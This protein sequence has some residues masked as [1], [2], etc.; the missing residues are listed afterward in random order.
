[1]D[2]GRVPRHYQDYIFRRAK[3]QN[4]I[5]CL[6]TGSGKT[7]IAC[8]LMT[9]FASELQEPFSGSGKRIFFL[10]PQKVLVHQQAD[11]IRRTTPFSE[12]VAEI[13]GDND[14][15][16]WTAEKWNHHLNSF[17][18]FVMIHDIFRSLLAMGNVL[19]VEKISLIVLD[20]AHHAALKKKSK[21][22]NHP[23]RQILE[24]LSQKQQ[25]SAPVRLLGLT[26]SLINNR[27]TE[28]LVDDYISDLETA[29]LNAECIAVDTAEVVR[30][31]TNAKVIIWLSDASTGQR[32]DGLNVISSS[33]S[34]IKNSLMLSHKS[35]EAKKISFPIDC[36]EAGRV[37]DR[38]SQCI[39]EMSI[40]IGWQ[41]CREYHK[42]L[43]DS[44]DVYADSFSTYA[45]ILRVLM[46][47]VSTIADTL[48][49]LMKDLTEEEKIV[50]ISSPKLI[51]LL[52][53]LENYSIGQK[54]FRGI[55]FVETRLEAKAFSHWIQKVSQLLPTLSFVKAEYLTGYSSRPGFVDKISRLSRAHQQ[56]TMAK[57]RDGGLNLLVATSV[58]EEGLDVPECNCV[59]RYHLPKTY[60]SYQ[61]SMGR[62]RAEEA[63]FFLIC[64]TGKEESN[65]TRDLSD[66]ESLGETITAICKKDKNRR[67][68]LCGFVSSLP[69]DE[70]EKMEKLLDA[71]KVVHEVTGAEITAGTAVSRV[72]EYLAQLSFGWTPRPEN[73]FVPTGSGYI[74]EVQLPI[75][76]GIPN[77]IRGDAMSSE[78]HAKKSAY[79]TI[80]K[81]LMDLQL[82]D[83]HLRPIPKHVFVKKVL[84]HLNLDVP[85]E[86]IPDDGA[87]PGTKKRKQD[88][89]I[90][91]PHEELSSSDHYFLYHI[92]IDDP[93]SR[94]GSHRLA[95]L[96]AAELPPHVLMSITL[97]KKNRPVHV[98]IRSAG[99]TSL[100]RPS[101]QS[102]Q[103][104]HHFVFSQMLDFVSRV[105]AASDRRQ[106]LLVAPL[107]SQTG[108]IDV[109]YMDTLKWKAENRTS[110]VF[111][112]EGFG[113]GRSEKFFFD[114]DQYHDAVVRKWYGLPEK[115]T[116]TRDLKSWSQSWK[117]AQIEK[118]LD[119][120][121]PDKKI[122][123]AAYYA[124]K[125]KLVA[126]DRSQ[127]LLK[128]TPGSQ[129]ARLT[130]N[131]RIRAIKSMHY[132]P[133][134]CEVCPMSASMWDQVSCLPAF[135]HRLNQLRMALQFQLF[136]AKTV[137]LDIDTDERFDELRFVAAPIARNDSETPAASSSN[138]SGDQHASKYLKRT[139]H[140]EKP[141]DL[142]GDDRSEQMFLGEA[143]DR[144]VMHSKEAS[145]LKRVCGIVRRGLTANGRQRVYF[146]PNEMFL[147]Q[148]FHSSIHPTPIQILF[149][150]LIEM[151]ETCN[152]TMKKLDDVLTAATGYFVRDCAVLLELQ[153]LSRVLVPDDSAFDI[154]SSFDEPPLGRSFPPGLHIEVFSAKSAHDVVN[155][156]RLET[157]GDAFIK[158][159]V[160]SYL[161]LRSSDSSATAEISP[162]CLTEGHLTVIK[163]QLVSNYNLYRLSKVIGFGEKM[164]VKELDP[165]TNWLP[166]GFRELP[167]QSSRSKHAISDKAIA[168]SVEALVGAVLLKMG[169]REAIKL[170]SW[171]GLPVTLN[172]ERL[173]RGQHWLPD[174]DP[175]SD[176]FSRTEEIDMKKFYDRSHI[177]RLEKILNYSFNNKWFAIC[178]ITH[179]SC[180]DNWFTGSYEKQ[181][182]LGDAV[183]DR[184]IATFCFEYK[185]RDGTRLDP[186]QMTDLRSALVNNAYL[187]CLLVKFDLHKSIFLAAHE[188]KNQI[189]TCAENLRSYSDQLHLTIGSYVMVKSDEASDELRLVP[190][191][192]PKIL[193]DVLEALIGAI[194]LDSGRSLDA[195][196]R[197]VYGLMKTE[198]L[199]FVHDIPKN[200]IR[201]IY[202]A[203][204]DHQFFDYQ[205]TDT[206][207]FAVTLAFKGKEF[208]GR[209]RNFKFARLHAAMTALI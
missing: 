56:E 72:H 111:N 86:K 188:T 94:V 82:L 84:K 57:F 2:G 151:E 41:L 147:Q 156:E 175:I 130:P 29:F 10:V 66:F 18:I 55:I 195:V 122:S 172:N 121:L 100:P 102:V 31:K 23:Y 190:I 99:R 89:V 37:M 21:M 83:Q 168:D 7:Y 24:S 138:A 201:R 78:L 206:N 161:H 136:L 45:D 97:Y 205:Q 127:H 71:Q 104:F 33:L 50:S 11:E 77:L 181:E 68:R 160:S 6:P 3:E 113:I 116:P 193:G 124:D 173:S 186:G 91:S 112:E 4:V 169:D 108:Q 131:E 166:P 58:L 129:M 93:A 174:I 150:G 208:A 157:L 92:V 184:L 17:K 44:L 192:V 153:E 177:L 165:K 9:Y 148:K 101:L 154:V 118:T 117:V 46:A 22:S 14:T 149:H 96:S 74:C 200:P 204:P 143:G 32:S 164:F 207:T 209:G 109:E 140:K 187:G 40:W 38:L 196:W 178:A 137:K 106:S 145:F 80:C 47:A 54:S 198:L 110:L 98:A 35:F 158:F 20:E 191:E 182:F 183:L 26:A 51:R 189:D 180:C 199:H 162:Y 79:L 76:S 134:F 133:E 13:T 95:L 16:F 103:W 30:Y 152:K 128:V 203:D 146:Q 107:S 34:N 115:D 19:P 70:D 87:I 48:S 167:G 163:G 61:Q 105:E 28:D 53:L 36:E 67:D 60:R 88:Y 141:D 69:R 155:S 120:T 43:S 62:A 144:V 85:R 75:C 171:M 185:R 202:E 119:D 49:F 125:Y 59:I 170:L 12:D 159:A 8:M 42:E 123:F 132:V 139:L 135:F 114:A 197:V 142:Y 65:L 63:A 90:S 52:Q 73:K 27:I 194:Y 179:S 15:D 25:I 39:S 126:C 81:T 5:A 64:N 1:M 176:S